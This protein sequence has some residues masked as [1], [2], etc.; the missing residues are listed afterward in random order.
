MSA[1]AE[2]DHATGAVDATDATDA[3]DAGTR[4]RPALAEP[5]RFGVAAL[6]AVGLLGVFSAFWR[7]DRADWKLDE[8]AYAQAGWVLVHQGIDPNLGHPPFA[9]LLF[10]GAQ[11][12]LGQ[13]LAAVRTVSALGFLGAIAV[14]FV[15]GRR[16]AGWWTGIVAAGLFAVVPR[17]MVV[18]GWQ[19]AELRIDRYGMLE[20]VAGTLVLVGLWLGW[21]WIVDGGMRWAVATGVVL[22]LAGASKLNALIV[23]VPVVVV[24]V[25]YVWGRAR[26]AAETAAVVASAVVA[27]LLPF[28]VFGRRAW[29]QVDQTLR[30]PAERARGGHQLV[31]GS[32]VYV[33]SPWWANLR[34]QLD[35][36]G[37]ILVAALLVGL[38]FVLLSRRRLVVVYLLAATLALVFTA[39]S[40]PVALPHYRAIWT[41]PLI[42]L[43]AIGLTEQVERLRRG[44]TT[45]LAPGPVIAA[46]ALAVLVV[47]GAGSMVQLATMGDGD[48]RHLAQE[49]AADGVAPTKVLVYGE[50]VAPYFPGAIDSLAPFDDGTVPAQMVVLDPSLTDAVPAASVDQWRS[51]ARSWGLVPHRVGRLEAWWAAP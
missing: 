50:S 32:S 27:F 8:D 6:A 37:P 45:R 34:Y 23:I 35:A 44:T 29:D 15:F 47:V 7:L 16:V 28:A 49:A 40:S 2:G 39:M 17:T 43:I 18:G 33:R 3:V 10:G 31:L 36:D 48:Y 38:A 14:L 20:A 19:V 24:G 9:K 22:G 51:W 21:R 42:L 25:A 1:T 12:V 13:N 30:F 11:V 26:L 41:A 5:P 4:R 46:V